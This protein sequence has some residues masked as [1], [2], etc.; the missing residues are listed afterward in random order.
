MISA[1]NARNSLIVLDYMLCVAQVLEAMAD[2]GVRAG[3]PRHQALQ[4]AAQTMKGA[5]CM[6]LEGGDQSQPNTAAALGH[7]GVLKDQVHLLLTAFPDAC[8]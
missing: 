5:A 8:C 3:L 1:E 6:V 4:L 7:P 2:G